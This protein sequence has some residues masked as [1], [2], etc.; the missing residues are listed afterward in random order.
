MGS[1]F[2]FGIVR[3]HGVSADAAVHAWLVASEVL[4][5]ASR[6]E[7]IRAATAA[8]QADAE[9]GAFFALEKAAGAATAW[10]LRNFAPDAALDSAVGRF[11]PAFESLSS[12]FEDFLEAAERERFERIYRELRATVA[13]GELA[14]DLA[15][16]AFA[17]HLLNVL[18]V[19]LTRKLPPE[20]VAAAYFGLSAHLD[21]SRLEAAVVDFDDEDR[22]RR[23]AAQELAVELREGRL[24]L[25]SLALEAGSASAAIRS[26]TS[27][28]PR[29]FADLER[30]LA[31]I[32]TMQTIPLPAVHVA[33]RAIARFAEKT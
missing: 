26:L 24:Q 29:E 7:Q 3:D 13:D 21:F 16:L 9:T 31:E 23:R 6:A 10:A 8:V 22:W 5:V 33:A 1:T 18:S 27:A 32:A 14:H 20:A 2:V 4:A 25:T 30:L 28:R 17:D 12:A 15:R 19:A 11:R